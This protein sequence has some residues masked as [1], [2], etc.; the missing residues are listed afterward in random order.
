VPPSPAEAAG[1]II[2]PPEFA[3]AVAKVHVRNEL[4]MAVP[5][6]IA[7]AWLSRATRW[8]AWYPN[9][10]NVKLVPPGQDDLGPGVKFTW[11]TFGVSLS[12]E[13]LEWVPQARLAW[14]ARGLGV[15]AYHAWLLEDSPGGCRVLTEETQHGW[16]CRLS[17]LVFPRRMSQQ[18]QVWL[19]QLAKQAASGAP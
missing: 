4:V 3:P 9:S 7:W 1:R 13:V 19:E 14:N 17:A 10:A 15:Y 16:A 12:S 5:R 18:H 11:K 2:W 6:S 8:P